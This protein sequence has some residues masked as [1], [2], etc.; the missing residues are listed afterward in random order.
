MENKTK[1]TLKVNHPIIFAILHY[2]NVIVENVCKWYYR[3]RGPRWIANKRYKATHHHDINWENP[4]DIDEKIMYLMFNTDTTEWTRLADKYAVRQF[5]TDRGCAEILIPL[6]G[7]W[8]HS[9]D[10]DFEMLPK[11]FVLK[12]NHGSGDVIIVRDKTKLNLEDIRN[13]IQKALDAPFGRDTA[14]LHYT[15]IKPCII[16]EQYLDSGDNKSI[17]DYKIWC[18]NGAPYGIFTGSERNIEK[19]TVY[20]NFFSLDWQR[21][22]EYMSGEYRNQVYVPKPKC[23]E[24]MIEYAKVLSD[25]FPEVR[26]DFYDFDGKV[27][28][29]EMT[30]SSNSAS[31]K[32]FTEEFLL[33]LGKQF[34]VK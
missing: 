5:V 27:Y 28:F 11:S 6:L 8:N 33:E 22:D 9:S 10:I 23:L 16:A 14:E 19:H 4:K 25:G 20:Y 7:K 32:F 1:D 2:C 13:R 31:Q 3:L 29:G 26:V 12:S 15:R 30:F 24:K 21:H 18:F 34:D 17:V